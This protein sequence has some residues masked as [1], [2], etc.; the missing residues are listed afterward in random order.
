MRRVVLRWQMVTATFPTSTTKSDK[1]GRGRTRVDA[2]PLTIRSR[3][4]LPDGLDALVR[5]RLGRH[6]EHGA[7]LIERV[8][9]RFDDVNGPRGGVDT[10][11]RIQLVISSRPS[12]QVEGR[13]TSPTEAFAR[14]A[15]TIKSALVKARDE[16]GL[17]SRTRRRGPAAV[18]GAKGRRDAG[19]DTASVGVSASDRK[20]GDGRTA[21]RNSKARTTKATVTLEDSRTRPSRKSTRRGANGSK[22]SQGKERTAVAMTVAPRARAARGAVR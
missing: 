15:A 6:L 14:A 12:V 9:V 3:V 5:K 21:R 11:C 1:A 2:T 4:S 17:A 16:H 19:V 18:A 13:G 22:P 20:A 7:T 10:V 8:T